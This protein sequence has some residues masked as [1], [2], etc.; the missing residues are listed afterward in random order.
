MECYEIV[1]SYFLHFFN[2]PL[3]LNVFKQSATSFYVVLQY[4]W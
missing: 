3:T 2:S 1:N 4:K